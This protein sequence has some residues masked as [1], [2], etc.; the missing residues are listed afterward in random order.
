MS[1]EIAGTA[2]AVPALEDLSLEEALDERENVLAF[3]DQVMPNVQ[4]AQKALADYECVIQLR[5]EQRQAKKFEHGEWRGEFK[6]VKSGS[7]SVFQPDVLRA[8]IEKIGLVPAKELEDALQVIV[9]PPIVKADL[10]KLRKLVDYGAEVGK[11]IRFHIVEPR[12]REVFTL[13]RIPRNVTPLL[14]E[15]K[16]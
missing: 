11:Q 7:A 6:M 3:L 8:A 1:T 2:P 10:R 14:P 13:E 16:G 9:P 15:V 4:K 12:E 5:M